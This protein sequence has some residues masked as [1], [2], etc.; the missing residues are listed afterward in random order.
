MKRFLLAICGTVIML[1]CGGGGGGGG[2]YTP[3]PT[4]PTIYVSISPSTTTSVDAGQTVK[5]AA[6]V[7]NDSSAKGVTWTVSGVGVTGAAAGTLT[8]TSTTAATYVAPASVSANL[9]ATVTATSIAD[10]TESSS[11][12][13]VVCTPPSITTTTLPSATPNASYSATLQATGGVGTLTWGLASGTLPAGLSLSASGA[14]TGTPTVSGSS[15]FTVQVTDSSS[16]ATGGPAAAQAALSL[17]VVTAVSIVTTTLPVGSQGAAYVDGLVATGGTAPYTW[18]VTTG[19]LPTGLSLVPGSGVISGTPTAQGTF[20]FTVSV[21]DSCPTPQ[22]QTRSLSIAIGA[23]GPLTITTTAL[24]NATPNATYSSTLAAS[25][26]VSPLTWSMAAGSLPPG[27]SLSNSG[28]ISGD[29][30]VSGIFTFTVQVTDST[31][32][33]SGG[34]VQAQKP[35]SLTVVTVVDIVTTSLPAGYQTIVYSEALAA[36]G[37]TA[38]YTWSV[39]SG[40]LPTGLTLL[41]GSGAI[42]GTPATQGTFTFTVSVRDSSPTPQTQT[43]ALSIAIGANLP[44]AITTTTLANATP[45][46]DYSATL[47]AT[48]GIPPLTWSM[49]AGSLPTGLS[50]SGSG[51]ISGDPTVPGVATFTVQVTDSTPAHREA[52]FQSKRRS[53]LL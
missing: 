38:P 17:T 33:A 37:G 48:G 1:A 10:S 53:A 31:P 8:N 16:A 13:V 12:M 3:P 24:T 45:N 19:S 41:P 4:Q 35:L 36:S 39:A 28:V 32:V 40:S 14:I 26:G 30:T 44:L 22:T 11:A 7:G 52:R 47:A 49:A 25:G 43:R 29:P 21:R 50:L 6:T 34:P 27:L 9:N 2:G 15:T 18:S 23:A 5:F 20:T 46:T 51:V 42:S